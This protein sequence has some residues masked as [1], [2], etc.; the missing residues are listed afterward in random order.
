MGKKNR[1]KDVVLAVQDTPE[2][3]FNP[4]FSVADPAL[5][6]FLGL[7][8]VGFSPVSEESALGLT[9]FY[10]C[11]SIIAGTIAGLPLK[12]YRDIDEQRE[13]VKSFLDNPAGPYRLTPYAWK[14]LVMVHLL[15]RGETFLAHVRN[16]AGAIIGLWPVHPSA[17]QVEWRGFD[18]YFEV[19]MADGEKKLY[20]PEDMTQIMAMTTDGTRGISPLTLFRRT[21]QLGINGEVAASRAF[22]NGM[23]IAGIVSPDADM[24]EDDAKAIKAGI[25]AKMTGVENAGDI[26]VVNRNLKF[27]PWAMTNADAEFLASREFQVIEFCRMLGVPPH[28]VGATEKQTSWG[29]GVSEQ[30]VGL[31]RYTLMSWTSRIEESVSLLLPN[32]RFAE[33]DYSGLLQ[34]SPKEE[35][36]LLI[37]QVKAG[38]LTADEARAIRNLK[39][40]P[41]QEPT[42]APDA[43]ASDE[44]DDANE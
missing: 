17:V 31:A 19:S 25:N 2:L 29:T 8:G 13:R 10:R 28:L 44:G 1:R 33:F 36:G 15:T 30:N 32:P 11:I 9:A 39:P 7:S 42:P 43:T 5:A 12:T 20:G 34:G 40:L 6:E 22:S 23:L 27:T 16:N 18:K 26:A 3:R 38:I 37:E 35:I 14:E 41:K 21:I 24:S 4:T